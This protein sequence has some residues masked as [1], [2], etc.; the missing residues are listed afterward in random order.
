MAAIIGLNDEEV[1]EVC[2]KV[3]SGFVVPVNYNTVGQVVISGEKMQS[4]EAEK[5]AKEMG[6]KKVRVLKTA[7][8]FHTKKLIESSNALRKDL[9]NINVH[10]FET[11]VVK[12]IDGDIYK[13]TDNVKDILAVTL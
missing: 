1:E 12:N 3:K 6:A 13:E 4:T 7:G 10:K 5:I 11:K 8:P 2:K 9:E